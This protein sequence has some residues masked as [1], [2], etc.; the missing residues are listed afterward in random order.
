MQQQGYWLL[1]LLA[2]IVIIVVA[3]VELVVRFIAL[4]R[5]G[6]RGK[7]FFVIGGIGCVLGIVLIGAWIYMRLPPWRIVD[8][9]GGESERLRW[10]VGPGL[11]GV[12]FSYLFVLIYG[13]VYVVVAVHIRKKREDGDYVRLDDS[14][15]L[16]NEGDEKERDVFYMN[17]LQLVMSILIIV[18]GV[19]YII[20]YAVPVF[21]TCPNGVDVN[22]LVL[23]QGFKV[24][25]Y[26]SGVKYARQMALS[27]NG[28]LYVGSLRF[29]TLGSLPVT[30][31]QDTKKLGIGDKVTVLMNDL[32]AP[33]GV[34]IRNGDLYVLDIN[35]LIRFPDIDNQVESGLEF[36]HETVTE[37]FPD[38]T[39][40][41]Y[42]YLRNGPDGLLYVAIGSPCNICERVS[43]F[44]TIGN[45]NIS[46]NGT[47]IPYA[48][49][50]YDP[51]C[52]GVRNSVGFDFHPTTKELWF[53][54]NGR[55]WL[56]DHLPHDE[57]NRAYKKNL[58]FG[59]PYCYDNG[60]PDPD[61]NDNHNCS[62]YENPVALMAPHAA[63]VGM[64]FYS[65]NMFPKEYKNAVFIAEH[66]SM[67]SEGYNGYQ[68]SVAFLDPTGTTVTQTFPFLTGFVKDNVACGRPA[69]ILTMPDGSIL[70]S[71]DKAHNIYRISYT[72]P[73]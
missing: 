54:D 39:Q 63:A 73:E 7:A 15:I 65:G 16:I 34:V 31:V 1:S 37:A 2:P 3:I 60:E 72:K 57:L 10:S 41:G 47:L 58:D 29:G 40:N 36:T 18:A 55:D 30:I 12:F 67:N 26:A 70:V 9:Q 21:K 8:P 28:N 25:L 6:F 64:H 61:F 35:K 45:I 27:P 49:S 32:R 24:E 20:V 56:G 38:V 42:K 52:Y 33:S 66:G 44:F 62:L 50:F 48:D 71:D 23:P 51:Y 59:F 53:T 4:N 68:V 43:P 5:V 11:I 19:V 69:D 13:V 14:G 22:Q 17:K 46:P